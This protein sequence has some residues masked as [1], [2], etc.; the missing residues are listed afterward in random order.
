MIFWDTF[1]GMQL[2]LETVKAL[3]KLIVPQNKVQFWDREKEE[4]IRENQ[5]TNIE[6]INVQQL[7]KTYGRTIFHFW[8]TVEFLFRDQEADY[9]NQRSQMDIP[10]ACAVSRV[11]FKKYLLIKNPFIKFGLIIENFSIRAGKNVQTQST[12]KI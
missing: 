11:F 12:L 9:G 3:P 7:V 10:L 5:N 8:S 2:L 1:R 4:K 6:L